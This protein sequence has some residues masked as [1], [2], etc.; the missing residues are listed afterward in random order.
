VGNGFGNNRPG[1]S[2][3]TTARSTRLLE[4]KVVNTVLNT[5]VFAAGMSATADIHEERIQRIRSA[6]LVATF[7]AFFWSG[8]PLRG[9]TS[10]GG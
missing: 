8:V 7:H 2:T 5:V 9:G 4:E 6:G 10:I 3:A 1:A